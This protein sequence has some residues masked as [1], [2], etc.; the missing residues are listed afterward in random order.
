MTV[1]RNQSAR[2]SCGKRRNVLLLSV[3]LLSLVGCATSSPPSV[4]VCPRLPKPPSVTTPTPLEDYSETA[5]TVIRGWQNELN[6][7]PSTRSDY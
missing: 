6:N 1:S 3:L 2:P 5:R 7:M 4:A